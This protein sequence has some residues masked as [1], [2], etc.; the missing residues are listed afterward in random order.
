MT[1]D[2]WQELVAEHALGVRGNGKWA[3][4]EVGLNVSRQNGKGG[5]LEIL[6]LGGI[7]AFGERLI[8]HSAHEFATANEAFIRMEELLEEGGLHKHLKPRGGVSR[9]HG[10]EG[11]VF[12]TNQRI[13]YRTRTKGGGRG[14][15]CDR[16]I[17]DEGMM[18]DE[19]AHGALIPTLSARD[20][21]QVIYAGSAVDQQVHEDGVVFARIRERAVKGGDPALAYFEW[22]A[23]AKTD[24]GEDMVPDQ[25]SDE[26][27]ADP[28]KWAQANPGLGI[29]ISPDHI[30]HELVA[31][32]N[33]SFAVERLGIGDYPVTEIGR[34]HV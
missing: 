26:L 7:F 11:F 13:R 23:E 34:A 14:F 6:E 25:L 1:P 16:L 30:G 9:S 31:L 10:M 29:R 3:A 19:F 22:S 4:F 15:T 2:P 18:I 12:K 17:L 24:D 21:P 27:L 32:D 20:N 8:I 5:V 33:R 28:Q